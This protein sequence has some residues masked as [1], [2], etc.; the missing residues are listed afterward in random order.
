MKKRI[1]TQLLIAIIVGLFST[2][3]LNKKNEFPIKEIPKIQINQNAKT[4]DLEVIQVHLKKDINEVV[5]HDVS[6][7]DKELNTFL[8]NKNSILN[9]EAGNKV[10][11][12]LSE[13]QNLSQFHVRKVLIDKLEYTDLEK[14]ERINVAKSNYVDFDQEFVI[15]KDYVYLIEYKDNNVPKGYESVIFYFVFLVE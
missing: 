9:I 1:L 7:K 13:N 15:E 14:R 5:I 6:D 8:E 3:F 4:F 12:V 11:F 10:T 2:W